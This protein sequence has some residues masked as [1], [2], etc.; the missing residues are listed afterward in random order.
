MDGVESICQE[1]NKSKK[2][3]F[4]PSQKDGSNP[5]ILSYTKGFPFT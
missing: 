2:E 3:E 4:F 1:E 5:L